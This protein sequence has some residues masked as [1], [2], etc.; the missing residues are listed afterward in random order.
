MGDERELLIALAVNR[1]KLASQREI[2]IAYWGLD[3]VGKHWDTKDWMR[4]QIRYRLKVARKIE[5]KRRGGG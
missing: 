2:A 5:R 4:A 1:A 3:E